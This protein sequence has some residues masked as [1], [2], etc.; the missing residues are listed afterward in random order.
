MESE[1]ESARVLVVSTARKVL[2]SEMDSLIGCRIIVKALR[3]LGV[4]SDPDL[5]P[6]VGI[7]SEC[8]EFPEAV[9]MWATADLAGAN[10]ERDRYLALVKPTILDACEAI[11]SKFG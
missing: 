9:G 1:V 4:R 8:D 11:I 7:E 2:A 3:T 10:A 6:L 5:N